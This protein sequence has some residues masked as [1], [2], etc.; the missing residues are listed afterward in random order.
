ML[1]K[2]KSKLVKKAGSPGR[3]EQQ[4]NDSTDVARSERYGLTLLAS[5]PPDPTSTKSYPVDVVAIHGLNGDAFTTWTHPNGTLWLRD[6]LP[7]FLPGCRV[8]TYGYPSQLVFNSS[9]AG[10][11]EYARNLLD[12]LRNVQEDTAEVSTTTAGRL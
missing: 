3:S 11:Q 10:V 1:K 5:R 8:F 12:S 7:Q 2:L 6:L 9:F 4:A